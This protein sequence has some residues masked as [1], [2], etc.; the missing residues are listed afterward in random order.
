M[1][2]DVIFTR[3]ANSFVIADQKF[4]SMDIYS[5]QGEMFTNPTKFFVARLFGTDCPQIIIYYRLRNKP[6]RNTLLRNSSEVQE[7]ETKDG[8]RRHG[9]SDINLV[10]F[11]CSFGVCRAS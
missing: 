6:D 5:Y 7:R 8:V 11:F 10:I 9:A 1:D 2:T 4:N 3:Y